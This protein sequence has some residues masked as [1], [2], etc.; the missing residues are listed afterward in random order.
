MKLVKIQVSDETWTRVNAAKKPGESFDQALSR[1]LDK[2]E[3][4]KGDQP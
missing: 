3:A 4:D 2:A 1:L